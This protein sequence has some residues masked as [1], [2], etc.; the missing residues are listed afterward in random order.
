MDKDYHALFLRYMTLS[1]MNTLR[2]RKVGENPKRTPEDVRQAYKKAQSREELI[3][4]AFMNDCKRYHAKMC[5]K[6]IGEKF[7]N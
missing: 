1:R 2:A 3:T 7:F 6:G 5:E 4:K